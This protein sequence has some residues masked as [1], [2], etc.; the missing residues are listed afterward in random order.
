MAC[1]V[2]S[3]GIPN[4]FDTQSSSRLHFNGLPAVVEPLII[5]SGVHIL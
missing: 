2:G 5:G 1:P 4:Y 3:V